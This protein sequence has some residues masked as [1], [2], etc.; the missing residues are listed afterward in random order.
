MGDMC[1]CTCKLFAYKY[2]HKLGTNATNDFL[3]AHCVF[4]LKMNDSSMEVVA[5]MEK[6]AF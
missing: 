3:K 6:F 5:F 2:P 4:F 1:P